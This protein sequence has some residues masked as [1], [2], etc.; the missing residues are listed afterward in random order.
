MSNSID[1][2]QVMAADVPA[3]A[4]L[5]ERLVA[6]CT[7]RAT[8]A[9]VPVALLQEVRA[10]VEQIAQEQR[11]HGD[12][13]AAYHGLLDALT[14]LTLEDV[15]DLKAAHADAELGRALLVYL[16]YGDKYPTFRHTATCAILVREGCTLDALGVCD[17]GAETL[18]ALLWKALPGERAALAPSGPQAQESEAKA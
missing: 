5:S 3:T 1:F 16:S 12:T 14:P 17:C 18:T 11:E 2:N 4:P 13:K 6:L 15:R 10:L 9:L 8:H 7:T